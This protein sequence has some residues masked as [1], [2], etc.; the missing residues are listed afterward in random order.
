MLCWFFF[1]SWGDFFVSAV[2]ETNQGMCY[3]S[4]QIRKFICKKFHRNAICNI[5]ERCPIYRSVR[6]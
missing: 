6:T 4:A 2:T 3:S 1:E 5:S